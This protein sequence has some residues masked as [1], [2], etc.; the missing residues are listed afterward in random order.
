MPSQTQP[1]Q[2]EAHE[3]K[4]A[5]LWNAVEGDRFDR[6]GVRSEGHDHAADTR[7]GKTE[8]AIR[9]A[10]GR[11]HIDRGKEPSEDIKHLCGGRS[12][13]TDST[14]CEFN[15]SGDRVGGR[16]RGDEGKGQCVRKV[17]AAQAADGART[18]TPDAEPTAV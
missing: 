11:V 12:R 13:S 3:D 8:R 15:H 2:T 16:A 17:R 7:A 6:I 14:H 10:T 4:G 5:G 18:A 9:Y 1:R